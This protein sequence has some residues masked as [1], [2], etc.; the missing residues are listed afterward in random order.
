MLYPPRNG[1]KDTIAAEE[2]PVE[3]IASTNALAPVFAGPIQPPLDIEAVSSRFMTRST[4][5]P[6]AATALAV[7]CIESQDVPQPINFPSR[8]KIVGVAAVPTTCTPVFGFPDASF[9]VT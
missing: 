3:T 1:T 9:I 7:A 2:P 8:I 4:R 5:P 6:L